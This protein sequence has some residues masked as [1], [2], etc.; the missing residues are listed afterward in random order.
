MMNARP[1]RSETLM[2][3]HPNALLVHH[4]IQAANAG[5]RQTLRALWADDIVW[6]V[7]GASPWQGE[8]K[9]AD[10]IFEYLA[11][12]GDLGSVGFHADIEDVLVS[13]QRAAA[14]CHTRSQLGNRVLDARFMLIMEIG[15]RRVREVTSVPIDPDRVAEFWRGA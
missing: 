10:D 5:D 8:I 15:D 9:G 11:D 14:L 6:N 7:K 2:I 12:L 1:V 3:E 13:G 4:L